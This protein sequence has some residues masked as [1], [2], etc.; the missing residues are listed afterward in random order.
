MNHLVRQQMHDRNEGQ[1]QL[2]HPNGEATSK[3][4]RITHVLEAPRPEL[5]LDL[6]PNLM[7]H[8]I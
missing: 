7:P 3:R 2:Q 5:K 6:Q 1:L 8:N 4:S